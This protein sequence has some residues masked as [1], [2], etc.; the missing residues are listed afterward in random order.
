MA[1]FQRG[2]NV[3]GESAAAQT[4]TPNWLETTCLKLSSPTAAATAESRTLTQL[5]TQAAARIYTHV[6][7][8]AK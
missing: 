2:E 1:G 4:K 3:R 5:H 8:S 6:N 7:V